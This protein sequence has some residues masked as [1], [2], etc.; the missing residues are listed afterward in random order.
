MAM[1]WE[2]NTMIQKFINNEN[3]SLEETIEAYHFRDVNM[4]LSIDEAVEFIK[5]KLILDDTV[6]NELD[7]NYNENNHRGLYECLTLDDLMWLGW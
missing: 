5:K 7:K 6:V 4:N 2:S 3:P 1:T